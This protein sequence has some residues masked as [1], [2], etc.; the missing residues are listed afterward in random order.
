MIMRDSFAY[1]TGPLP[2]PFDVRLVSVTSNKL[3]FSWEAVQRDCS[4][5]RYLVDF[6]CGN[7]SM[8][9]M[10]P[11][12]ATCTFQLPQTGASR[13]SLC[14]FSVSSIICND[15]IGR[16]SVPININLKGKH[17]KSCMPYKKKKYHFFC[18]VLESPEIR[19]VVPTYGEDVELANV[20]IEF[21]NVVSIPLLECKQCETL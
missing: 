3:T 11:T 10:A 6:D 1:I 19:S 14:D 13:P 9:P 21:E 5:L 18:I 15:I 2:P 8:N 16:K 20:A 17:N 4:T 12:S 7:C